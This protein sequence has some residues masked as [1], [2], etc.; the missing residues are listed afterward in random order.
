[1]T[2]HKSTVWQ[3]FWS[4]VKQ[5]ELDNKRGKR[6]EGH[7]VLSDLTNQ[8]DQNMG[9][10]TMTHE[11]LHSTFPGIVTLLVLHV[12]TFFVVGRKEKSYF[13]GICG[14]EKSH[15]CLTDCL[16]DIWITFFKVFFSLDK[17]DF[18]IS[19]DSF[20][21]SS[22]NPNWTRTFR[23]LRG[24][25]WQTA[26]SSRWEAWR[27]PSTSP[28]TRRTAGSRQTLSRPRRAWACTQDQDGPF[29]L[30]WTKS[31]CPSHRIRLYRLRTSILRSRWR[32]CLTCR[33]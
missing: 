3:K 22:R 5:W 23:G 26:F 7:P 29:R 32:L 33:T 27:T 6:F 20:G 10:V 17:L 18:I 25:E 12:I 31:L 28:V 30:R 14:S 13:V 19:I 9:T 16:S 15:F 21:D 4:S 1:M 8:M 2:P 11:H 24:D